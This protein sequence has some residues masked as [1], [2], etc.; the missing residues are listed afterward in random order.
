MQVTETLK[1]I[2]Y[3]KE[4][5]TGY[6]LEWDWESAADG[7][8]SKTVSSANLKHLEGCILS[9]ATTVPGTGDDTPA[10]SY[11]VTITDANG[12]DLFGGQLADRS[13]IAAERAIPLPSQIK[14]GGEFSLNIANAG[15]TN[16]GKVFLT[17]NK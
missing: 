12:V 13:A 1:P 9:D 3:T 16:T 4:G 10:G 8:A 14:I 2:G 17:F 7:S 11:D 6:V 15:D 5:A